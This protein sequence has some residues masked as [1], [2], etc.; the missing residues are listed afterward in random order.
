MKLLLDECVPKRLKQEFSGHEVFTIDKAGFKGLKNGNLLRAADGKYE[1]L[2]TVDKNMQHQ[3]N[4]SKLPLAI[5]VLS[6]FSNRFESLLPLVPKILKSLENIKIGEI[7]I[8]S[9]K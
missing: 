1:I 8:I 7:V 9:E 4:K 2:I 3:Q 5:L 6:S